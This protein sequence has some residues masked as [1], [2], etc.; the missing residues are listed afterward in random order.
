MNPVFEPTNVIGNRPASATAHEVPRWI[1]R[2]C[3][4]AAALLALL[5][6]V[7]AVLAAMS[8]PQAQ[9]EAALACAVLSLLAMRIGGSVQR[10]FL[11]GRGWL[12][13]ATGLG[14]RRALV[15]VGESVLGQARNERRKLTAV[16]LDFAD[17]LEVRDIYG[18]EVSHKVLL[19]V[20]R[21][22]QA[23]AGPQGTA[24]RTG[25]AQFTVLL[26]GANRDKAQ[27]AVHRALGK[28]CRVEFDAGDSEIVLVPDVQAETA[29]PDVETMDELYREIA[30]NLNEQ[31]EQ[32]KRRQRWLTRERERH[33]RPMSIH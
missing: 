8:P 5:A 29:A 18:R 17:L 21:K 9:P 6:L 22:M 3:H 30:R 4:G 11:A 23:I 26:P 32:E 19:R 28:P 7:L 2:A 24:F 27:A 25:K 1:P 15:H 13:T 33:S 16:V 31:R 14:N 20:A 10:R 12:D